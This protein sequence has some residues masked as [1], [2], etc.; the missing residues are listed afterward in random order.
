LANV[1]NS[2]NEPDIV[3]KQYIATITIQIINKGVI[4]P[5]TLTTLS[6]RNIPNTSTNITISAVPYTAGMPNC[7]SKFE[8]PP[9]SITTPNPNNAIMSTMSTNQ[10][11]TLPN[12]VPPVNLCITSLCP[13]ALN[14]LPNH[15]SIIP[16]LANNTVETIPA[17]MPTVPKLVKYCSI[18]CP[19]AKPAPTII[20]MNALPI[21]STRNI[22]IPLSN[23]LYK[24]TIL[25]LHSLY[26]C[27][28]QKH[29]SF[30]AT[31]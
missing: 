24:A 5:I 25:P 8:P 15:T 14:I 3:N 6:T 29:V 20:P 28:I 13:S 10:A 2:L 12:I 23:Y 31:S 11:M 27:T 22:F 21:F 17:R 9:A 30:L 18:S 26:I 1:S 19:E 4:L 7:C 16:T